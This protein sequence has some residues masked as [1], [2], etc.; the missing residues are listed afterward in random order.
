MLSRNLE[1]SLHR[2]LAIATEH[3]HEFATLEHLLLSLTDDLD[4][5]SVLR[6][7]GVEVDKLRQ[8]LSS[9][10]KGDLGDLVTA[11]LSEPKPTA[12]FQRVVQRAAIHVQSCGRESVTGANMIVALFSEKESQAVY[13]Y[14]S[15]I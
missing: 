12:G 15:K 1:Q 13:F 2:A 4:G 7:C 10:I 8:E 5:V 11:K 14:T 9:F 3:N 6:A